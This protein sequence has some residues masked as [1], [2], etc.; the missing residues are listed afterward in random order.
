MKW[1]AWTS[2]RR[3]QIAAVEY[4]GEERRALERASLRYL[5]YA[6]GMDVRTGAGR[7]R[8]VVVTGDEAGQESAR[9]VD[10]PRLIG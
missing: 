10:R 8:T 2:A 5:N 3:L 1:A 4:E 9:P 7:A 6:F